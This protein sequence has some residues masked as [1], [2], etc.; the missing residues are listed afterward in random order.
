M[1][2]CQRSVQLAFAA[3]LRDLLTS[4]VSVVRLGDLLISKVSF[5]AVCIDPVYNNVLLKSLLRREARQHFGAKK[6]KQA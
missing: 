2:P 4:E 1:L 5:S 6:C 3:R